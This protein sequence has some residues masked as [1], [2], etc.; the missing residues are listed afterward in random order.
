MGHTLATPVSL[1]FVLFKGPR[2]T[3]TTILLPTL[4]VPS[5]GF[6]TPTEKC[7]LVGSPGYVT[8]VLASLSPSYPSPP[9]SPHSSSF[10]QT[11]PSHDSLKQRH[12][13]NLLQHPLQQLATPPLT[14]ESSFS[15]PD[16]FL[17]T[18][19]P[20]S[21]SALKYAKNVAISSADAKWEG[22]V[23]ELPGKGKTLYINGKGAEQ[24]ML[25]ESIVALLDLA[26]ESLGCSALVI[27]LERS[28]PRIGEVLHS[29]MYVG[30]TV[31]TKPPFK[32]DAGY[33]LVGIEV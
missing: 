12:H 22:V 19:F 24:I 9:T 2:L 20:R 33:V 7:P 6:D 26:D 32:A 25:R 30:G 3:S 1:R 21:L 18:L 5:G 11:I 10:P 23:L 8:G 14:P 28:S 31:V 16:S 13:P 15:V 4:A 17:T 27:A 29:L